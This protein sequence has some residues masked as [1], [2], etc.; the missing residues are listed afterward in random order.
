MIDAF[1]AFDDEPRWLA[2]REEERG[3]KPTKPPY[4]PNRPGYRG[5]ATDPA[6]WATR[7]VAEGC[8][9]ELANGTAKTGIGIPLGDIGDNIFLGGT[10][11]DSSIDENGALSPWATRILSAL[12]T[13]SE[14]SPSGRGI[15]AF[16]YAAAGDTRRF[17]DLIGVEPGKW[18][19]KRGIPGL[20][21][22]D[23]GPGIEVY[24][25]AR[26]FTVTGRLWSVDHQ[27]IALLEWSQLEALAKLIP[28]AG[29]A[30]AKPSSTGG[31]DNSRSAAAFRKARQLIR[32]GASYDEMKEALRQDA[33]PSVRDWMREKGEAHGERELKRLWAR[34][35]KLG[36][37]SRPVIRVIDGERHLAADAGV[38]ALLAANA[39]YFVRGSGLVRVGMLPIKT[40]E[41]ADMLLPA[42]VPVGPA[43]L[44]RALAIAADWERFDRRAEEWRRIDPPAPIAEQ[45]L[46]LVGDELPFPPLDGVITCP[47]LRPDGSLL[48]E[49]GYDAQT[50]L[51]LAGTIELPPIPQRPSRAEAKAA[52]RL[53]TELLTG[54]PFV[55]AA[56]RSVALS[57]LITPVVRAAV[58]PAVP[59]HA[60]S[61]P[62]PG[63]G[64]SYLCNLASLIATGKP[65]AV[66]ALDRTLEE[67]EKRLVGALLA[68]H[69]V[70]C[71]D[72]ARELLQGP[73]L[74]HATEQPLIEL[75]RLGS[76]D[77]VEIPNAVSVFTNGNNLT[78]ADDLTRRTIL[79]ALDANCE[80]P[81][82]RPFTT[83]PAAI[84]QRDRGAYV[85]AGI[86]IVRAYLAAGS[87]NRLPPLPSYGPWS[88]RVRSAL[89]W[90][91]EA[92]P[93]ETMARLREAD[94]VRLARAE[95]F[96]AAVADMQT[97]HTVGELISL[98]EELDNTGARLRPKLHTALRVV[99]EKRGQPGQI[100]NDRLGRWL[101]ANENT[102]AAGHKLVADRSD[103]RRPRWR[104]VPI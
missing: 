12:G 9:K 14:V 57:M 34:A 6:T 3:G 95:A 44:G 43:A 21:G 83:N 91:D 15:K 25:A 32:A 81:E 64:K 16:F 7:I 84:V 4:D 52:L 48:N 26:F 70:I 45:I 65:C 62:A 75:R 73:I 71:I 51:Y 66:I 102:I 39:E 30:G 33:D 8:A 56:S 96:E 42:I 77:L 72:N 23:H 69:P 22:A 59:M 19:C 85:A 18:G 11:L 89:V 2:W 13:Y 67:T 31:R 41:G 47:S 17:L 29:S 38:D 60:I 98:A 54:F 28:P 58:G 36:Q 101:H 88:N 104:L 100:D 24:C 63:T 92:D 20:S 35:G 5:D 80:S 61:A 49:E 94:P 46:S 90:L 93:V 82:T 74:C 40:T 53:L 79:C 10:D 86:I 97:G 1:A 99:A 87:P 50:G 78:I 68:G 27:R 76:S 103:K 55:D 37:S